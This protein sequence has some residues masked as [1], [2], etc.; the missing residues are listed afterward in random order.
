MGWVDLVDKQHQTT[1]LKQAGA[2]NKLDAGWR[3]IDV[4]NEDPYVLTTNQSGYS[5]LGVVSEQPL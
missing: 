2:H 1:S 5:Q 3:I 4:S